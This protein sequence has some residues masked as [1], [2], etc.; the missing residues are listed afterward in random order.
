VYTTVYRFNPSP[1]AGPGTLTPGQSVPV[2]LT[3]KDGLNNPVQNATVYLSFKHAS[4][5]GSAT[6][7][8]KTLTSSLQLFTTD[9]TGSLTIT[10]TAPT[11]LPAS[12][13]DV[14][15][16]KSE[17][18]GPSPE[19][20][21]DAYDFTPGDP[22]ISI[23]DDQVVEGDQLP[24]IPAEFTVSIAPAQP[25]ATTFQYVTLCGIGDKGCG[26]DFTQVNS[27]ITVTIP[28]G[29]N[30]AYCTT[31]GT[32]D[33]STTAESQLDVKQFSYVG[34]N[35]G[36]TYDEGW[37]VEIENPSVGVIGRSI[38]DGMLLPDIE[39]VS[40]P[41]ADMYTGNA[42]AVPNG[43]AANP[44]DAS[45]PDGGNVPMFFT[46]TLGAATKNNDVTFQYATSDG[47][48][49]AGVDYVPTSGT[50]TILASYG[51]GAPGHQTSAII[52]VCLLP[53]ATADPGKTFNLTISNAQGGDG[54]VSIPAIC[55]TG[56]GVILDQ[57]AVSAWPNT[58]YPPQGQC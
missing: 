51:G 33:C 36:E 55:Q 53:G 50:A 9:S 39:G 44:T 42:S 34:G 5:G 6:A 24:G 30:Y 43:D 52:P 47:T 3:A 23:S 21:T 1:I 32:Q 49:T 56:Q 26:E 25:T 15:T 8:G 57:N 27:P 31:T 54:N 37:Y 10:Y 14:I 29:A 41:L 16:A 4:G 7:N 58:T 20:N 19:T 17:T 2:T 22:V 18:S 35:A 12:G 40:Q 28:A 46:V 38:A 48:A 45:C 13:T 11:P